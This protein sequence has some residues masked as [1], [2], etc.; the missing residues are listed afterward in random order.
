MKSLGVSVCRCV[1]AGVRQRPRERT[2]P[3]LIP[4]I[5]SPKRA[6]LGRPDLFVLVRRSLTHTAPP[7]TVIRQKITSRHRQTAHG[8]GGR[9]GIRTI[10]KVPTGLALREERLDGWGVA[11]PARGVAR[12]QA[13]AAERGG[14]RLE[15]V[16]V[17]ARHLCVERRQRDRGVLRELGKD[18]KVECREK[19]LRAHP[20]GERGDR[21]AVTVV[22]VV[23]GGWKTE[24]NVLIG[25]SFVNKWFTVLGA[26][27]LIP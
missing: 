1:A 13:D 3:G 9:G 14:Q 19:C 25:T 21:V 18:L 26:L 10:A 12:Q 5:L 2:V 20:G 8:G 4:H 16:W 11:Q 23:V 17:D 27:L 6:L 24:R 7:P 15:L 22:A